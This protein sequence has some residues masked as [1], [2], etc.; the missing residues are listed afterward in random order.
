[1]WASIA[2]WC[3]Q[4]GGK[5]AEAI[6]I[7][8]VLVF[9]GRTWLQEHDARLRADATV[10]AAQTQIGDLQKQQTAVHEAAQTKVV[11]LEKTAEQVKTAQ[12]AVKALQADTEVK[13]ALP[14]LTPDPELPDQLNVNALQ[15]FQGVNKCEQDAVQLGATTQELTIQKQITAQKDA[16]IAALKKKPSFWTRVKHGAIDIGCAGAAGALGALTKSPQA[17]AIGAMGIT[18]AC[19][20]F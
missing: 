6:I 16:Q 10:K 14:S 15:L 17:G 1:M 7:A 18:A 11:V 19:H 20:L 8:A 13:A 3:K 9:F 2:N 5:H 4:N 12:Q